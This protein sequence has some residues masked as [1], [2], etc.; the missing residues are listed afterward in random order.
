[1]P[2]DGLSNKQIEKLINKDIS[3][4]KNTLSNKNNSYSISDKNFKHKLSVIKHISKI[5]LN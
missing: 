1:M 3:N 5:V 4:I 2:V